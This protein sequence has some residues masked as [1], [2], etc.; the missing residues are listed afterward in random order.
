MQ[1]GVVKFYNAE[2]RFGFIVPDNGDK[3]VFFHITNIEGEVPPQEGDHVQFE[4]EETDRGFQIKKD[5]IVTR[6]A[7]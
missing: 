1:T 2:K 6:V 3:D 7:A 5:T 4:K